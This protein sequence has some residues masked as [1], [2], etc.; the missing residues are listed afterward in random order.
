M[1]THCT[2]YRTGKRMNSTLRPSADGNT[3]GV[4]CNFFE[5]FD[6]L[7]PEI[8][9][10]D[11]GLGTAGPPNNNHIMDYNYVYIERPVD[12]YYF[13]NKWERIK[14]IWHGY[15]SED[16]LASWR[17][18]ILETQQYITRSS[19]KWHDYIPDTFYGYNFNRYT[20][21]A[22]IS[23]TRIEGNP[24]NN[25]RGYMDDIS[26]NSQIAHKYL[27]Y[28]NTTSTGYT[29]AIGGK[30]TLHSDHG[31]HFGTITVA[32]VNDLSQKSRITDVQTVNPNDYINDL[33]FLPFEP[34]IN[35][36]DDAYSGV[37]INRLI[38]GNAKA[39]NIGGP[40]REA[41]SIYVESEIYPETFPMHPI[42]PLSFERTV[43]R[44]DI[45]NFKSDIDYANSSSYTK[46]YIQMLPF[47]TVELD[48]NDLI[49]KP[50]FL[51]SIET[52]LIT[53]NAIMYYGSRS[54]ANDTYK[55]LARSNVRIPVQLMKVENN[56][57]AYTQAQT[58]GIM[59]AVQSAL[60]LAGAS[61]SLGAALGGGK[62]I[63][64][65]S[66]A[67][68][69][70]N[71]GVNLASTTM[72]AGLLPPMQ[73]Y[74]STTG[75]PGSCLIDAQPTLIVARYNINDRDDA[76]FGRPLCEKLILGSQLT[77]ATGANNYTIKNPGLVVCQG[78]QIK[79]GTSTEIGQGILAAERAAIESAL[80]GGVYLE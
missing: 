72:Q 73:Y 19:I 66:G 74:N 2:F 54:V 51:I 60:G 29:T 24:W 15:T 13:I 25:M 71:S 12:R 44:F 59:S 56:A 18:T 77:G 70:I 53:G 46:Y 4:D 37:S 17:N 80:N 45:N 68:D 67:F 38:A 49:N 27:G 22:N 23:P 30:E 40:Q 28:I 34:T 21:S 5:P 20:E 3:W 76:R 52:D 7:S 64:L 35:S 69:L 50:N 79:S 61:A 36:L 39:Y 32:A 9:L 16:V 8:L 10:R 78:A 11:E 6:I 42:K 58:A 31:I 1:S 57:L 33:Y 43:W 55:I 63:D 47:G 75:A 26:W 14:G 62:G 65:A 41:A 48:A